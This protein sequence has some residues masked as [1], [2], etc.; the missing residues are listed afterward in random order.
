MTLSAEMMHQ[1]NLLMIGEVNLWSI[2]ILAALVLYFIGWLETLY[3]LGG[4]DKRV[5]FYVV[6]F[7]PISWLVY[8]ALAW[9]KG[10]R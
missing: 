9:K 8:Y 6:F 10:R 2:L 7:I 3:R 5:A 1:A 4:E